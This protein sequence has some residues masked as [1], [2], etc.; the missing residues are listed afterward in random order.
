MLIGTKGAVDMHREECVEICNPD[1]FIL[2]GILH[3]GEA[4]K[5]KK[6]S[7]ICLNTG[8]ND[9]VG[10]H[11]IQVKL[12]RYLAANGYNLIRFDDTGIGDSDGEL[13]EESIVN[14]FAD[15]ETGLFV[16]N[17]DAAVGFMARKFPKE[18]LVFL[19]FCG[20]G[21][22]AIHSAAN[23]RMI[24]GIIDIGGPITLSSK[25]YLNK[26]DPWEVRKNVMSYRSKI[27]KIRSWINFFTCKGDYKTIFR[28]LIHFVRHKIKG[29]YE[30]SLQQKD[31]NDVANLNKKFFVSF[32]AYVKSKRPTLFY[33][34]ELDSATWEFK[35][36]FLSRYEH[37]KI[38][39]DSICEFIEVEG[40]NHILSGSESQERMKRDILSWLERYF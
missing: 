4:T 28:S 5:Y 14:I 22:T 2:R 31:L 30:D 34:A 24:A 39:S 37:S 11:R 33:F 13:N 15:I 7:L 32:E 20:G 36:Y 9:M 29:E 38:W 12:S 35:K 40:A 6:V 25:E 18:K 23:N 17:A 10:W 16:P 27:F 19:G 21:L 1:G 3:H 26:K 8:L